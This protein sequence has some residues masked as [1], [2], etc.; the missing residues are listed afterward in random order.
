MD[1]SYTPTRDDADQRPDENPA[2]NANLLDQVLSNTNIRQAW[3]QVRLNKGAAGIDDIRIEQ[4]TEWIRPQWRT[5]REQ[6]SKGDYY[7]QP[8]KRIRIPKD[9]G[10][11]RL[12]GIP[13]VLDR[14][15]QQAIVQ[16]L[17]PRFDPTFSEHSYGFRPNRSAHDAV[18]QVQEYCQQKR[19]I[20]VDI[21]LS[22]FFDRVNH[23]LL[24]TLLGRRVRDKGLLQLIGRYLRAGIMDGNNLL[25]CYEGVPQ[26]GPL[27]PLLS[28][29]MLDPLDK[30]LEKRGHCFARYADDLI[31]LV[32]SQ[33]AGER[34]LKSLTGFI[35]NDLKLK[36]NTEKSQVVK[37]AHCKFL[38]FSFRG[39][40]IRWHPKSVEKF[41]RRVRELT[42]RTWDVS[43][44]T[45]IQKLSVYL[46]GWINYYG[47]GNQYQQ[48]VDLDNWIRRRIR[49]CY[50]KQWGR[51]RAKIRNLI[52][53]GLP[54]KAAVACGRSSKSWWRSSKSHGIN[55]ALG[56]KYLKQQGLFSLRDGWI[57]FHYG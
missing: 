21:D 10:G 25:P 42:N 11:E 52:R 19:R 29:V 46:R 39:Q 36:V 24:M 16:I 26:G 34:V 54:I 51:P 22:K 31:I 9:D 18:R 17:S 47:I 55:A 49:M 13:T 32:K 20:A 35:E 2:L 14:V 27:S 38:G 40:Y 23:D 4:F 5:L 50:W 30:E 7:P 45:K 6:L 48:C 53:L 12:L 37:S 15:I 33:R 1:P 56:L 8:V 3:Q 41:K 57:T 28:N 43:M 44:E